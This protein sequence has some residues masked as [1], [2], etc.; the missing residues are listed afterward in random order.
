MK[1]VFVIVFLLT[2]TFAQAE[3]EEAIKIIRDDAKVQHLERMIV[4]RNERISVLEEALEA[5][6]RE[7]IICKR[8][9]SLMDEK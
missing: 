8:L 7:R 6:E 3:S 5:S 9:V 2:V 4:E 1:G